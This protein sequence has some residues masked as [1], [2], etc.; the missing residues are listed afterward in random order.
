M[1]GSRWETPVAISLSKTYFSC[2]IF[3]VFIVFGQVAS[4]GNGATLFYPAPRLRS[5]SVSIHYAKR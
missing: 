4:L 2:C 5:L 1:G 3:M